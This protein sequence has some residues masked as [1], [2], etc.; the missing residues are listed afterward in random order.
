MKTLIDKAISEAIELAYKRIYCHDK[1]DI[2]CYAI[3]NETE[4]DAYVTL[5][6]DYTIH[7]GSQIPWEDPTTIHINSIHM[8]IDDKIVNP[9]EY[10][11]TKEYFT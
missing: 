11:V 6:I 4:E 8:T 5:D 7:E 9:Y 1:C 10:G 2:E 3:D